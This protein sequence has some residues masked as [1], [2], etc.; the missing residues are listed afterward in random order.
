MATPALEFTVPAACLSTLD[1]PSEFYALLLAGCSAAA[2]RVTLSSLYLGTGP[3]ER[4][5]LAALRSRLLA[6]PAL[7]AVLHFDLGRALRRTGDGSGGAP[8]SSAAL[9]LTLLRD[10]AGQPCP[11]L[12]ARARIDLTQLPAL[13]GVL[14]ALA[15]PRVSEGLGV[16]HA[17]AYVFDRH[18]AVLCGA[19][20]STDYFTTR[21]DRYV[22]VSCADGAGGAEG[23]AAVGAFADYLHGAIARL[24][25]LPGGH[26]L[27]A[28]GSVRV[29]GSNDK[30]S[31]S[32][33]SSSSSSSGGSESS[34]SITGTGACAPASPT[35]PAPPSYARL[36]LLSPLHG[37]YSAA[38]RAAL[39]GSSSAAPIGLAGCGGSAA[40]TV[41]LRPRWQLGAVGARADEGALR[42]LLAHGLRP[43]PADTLHLATGYFNLPSWL[44]AALVRARG[45]C[46]H[47]LTAS[48]LANGFWGARGVAGAIPLAYCQ[49]LRV[50]YRA[51]ARAGRL[52][53]DPEG[54]PR[55]PGIAIH[56]Y[57]REGWTFHAKG[58]WLQRAGGGEGA[59]EA[60]ASMTSLV[61]SSNYGM[62]WLHRD[63]EL[64][65]EV[66]TR[67]AGA[68]R[69][70]VAERERLF[71]RRSHVRAIG[72]HLPAALGYG[73]ERSVFDARVAP[74]RALQWR[75]AW[76]NG[77]W[78][79]AGCRLLKPFF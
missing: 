58:L 49:L 29:L 16:W 42:A 59:G 26:R 10:G 62:R 8:T 67:D 7:T 69:A 61:G 73:A 19:N 75:H 4:A 15:S 12:A 6:T 56:E 20:L 38:L 57:Q 30:G 14:G 74:H 55:A 76:A 21:Q 79:H 39:A 50:F 71:G 32:G 48:P 33:G 72:G 31:C 41:T 40:G 3:L 22:V 9:L 17:K 34:G 68:C 13:R 5:L 63:L 27:M 44:Q 54:A 43:A 23:R 52:M 64:Q 24:G 28:D 47:V 25:E 45:A 78:I 46:V 11:A 66:S 53:A 77:A 70:L 65:V 51:A 35:A 37:R 60:G 36:P 1:T 2:S 18:T